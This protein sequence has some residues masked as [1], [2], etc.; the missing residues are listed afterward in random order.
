MKYLLLILFFIP[1]LVMANT[2]DTVPTGVPQLFGGKYYKFNGY[3]LVDSFL[4]T[5]AGDTN[6]I[7]R[8]PAL[9][10]KSSDNRWYG[11]DRTRWRRFT[12]ATDPQNVNWCNVAVAGA[13]TTGNVDASQIVQGLIN[14]GCKAL[15]FPKGTYLFSSTVQ[16]KD[17]VMVRGDGRGTM[18]KLTKNLP[19]FKCGWALGGTK[20]TFKDL[21]F[22][23]TFADSTLQ[24]GIFA[25]SCNGILVDGINGYRLAG[26]GI[27]MRR[28]GFCCAMYT[29]NGVRG[30]IINNCYFDSCQVGVKVDTVAEFITIANTTATNGGIGIFTA[31]GSTNISACRLGMNNYGIYMT[32]GSN[33]SHGTCENTHLPHNKQYGIYITSA[34]N[35]YRFVG[36][37]IRQSE[38][39]EIYIENSALMN[40]EHNDIGTGAIIITNSTN[41]KFIDNLYWGPPAWTITGSTLSDIQNGET[42]NTISIKDRIFNKTFNITHSNGVVDLTGATKIRMQNDTLQFSNSGTR[43]F[44]FGGTGN[45]DSITVRGTTSAVAADGQIGKIILGDKIAVSQVVDGTSFMTIGKTN[46]TYGLDLEIAGRNPSDNATLAISNTNLGVNATSRMLWQNSA[47]ATMQMFS[48]SVNGSSTGF[49]PGAFHMFSQQS[50][51]IRLS[52]TAGDIAFAPNFVLSAQSYARYKFGTGSY[53]FG[54]ETDAP[55]KGRFQIN[56]RSRFDSLMH[57]NNVPAPPGAYNFLVHSTT[58]SGLYQIPVPGSNTQVLYNNAGTIAGDVGLTWNNTLKTLTINNTGAGAGIVV[59]SPVFSE[60]FTATG[61]QNGFLR[62]AVTNANTFSNAAAGG[63]Y[64]SDNSVLQYYAGSSINSFVPGGALIRSGGPGGL[65]IVANAAGAPIAFGNNPGMGLGEFARFTYGGSFLFGTQTDNPATGRF[66]IN[67]RMRIDSLLRLYNVTAPPSSYNVL[68]HNMDDSGTYQVPVSAIVGNSIT[69]INGETGPA[70]TIQGGT[71]ISVTP[72]TNTATIEVVPSSSALHHTLDAVYLT[73]A[74]SGTSE[75]DLYSYNIPSNT[76]AIDGRTV[77]FEVDGEFSDNTI[78]AQL[79]LYFGG[80]VTLNTGAVS[81]STAFT[82]WRLKGYII[83]TSSTTAHVTYELHAPGLATPVFVGYNNLTSLDFTIG[84][85]IKITA[86]AAGGSAGNGDISAHSWQ[87]I[88]RPQPI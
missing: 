19:A 18:V 75:T 39:A 6:N 4:M 53:L 47:G 79:K 22:T 50:G 64:S 17:S 28:T 12:Y 32:G 83:R 73:A 57:L 49:G 25:D 80:N 81:V 36:N 21:T 67:S 87:I 14:G 11:W 61:N 72:T 15:Y 59:N 41:N 69:S 24:D 43:H 46:A 65:N 70:Y 78:T 8:Y 27:R 3:V 82:A 26:S 35:G 55:A 54:T 66:R 1:S 60:P 76:L 30:N 42:V 71:A 5:A 29:M 63:L 45:N 10:F 62:I 56:S 77:N 33:N 37:M 20:T 7:P 31:G 16:M 48:S 23:G 85:I 86:Q 44:L 40:F 13:D 84:N 52:S 74:N 9:E 68:V 58:D 51:G 88:Y 2:R 34:L 38:T